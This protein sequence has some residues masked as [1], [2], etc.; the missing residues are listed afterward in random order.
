MGRG[1]NM[2]AR[3]RFDRKCILATFAILAAALS[4]TMAPAARAVNDVPDAMPTGTETVLHSFGEGPT[5]GK[6]KISDG[7]NP[8]GSLTYV[9][10]TRLLLGTT[11]T[12]TSQG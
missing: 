10:G 12:T 3:V 2:F 9:T 5:P 11:S 8:K 1:T 6:C 7:A 4:L